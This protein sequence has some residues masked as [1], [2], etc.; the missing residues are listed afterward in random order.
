MLLE[1]RIRNYRSIRD[2]I[3]VSF[4]AAGDKKLADTNLISTGINNLPHMV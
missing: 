3:V 1:F 4:V 2:E